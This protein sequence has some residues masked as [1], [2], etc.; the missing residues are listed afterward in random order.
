MTHI[1]ADD[2][3]NVKENAANDG[4]VVESYERLINVARSL[5]REKD[6][7]RL[8]EMILDEARAICRADAGTLYTLGEDKQFLTFAV[9][10]N[11]TLKIR[12]RGEQAADEYPRIPLYHGSKPNHAQVSS[13]AALTGETVNIGD[14]YQAEKF[15]FEGP[16]AFDKQTGYRTR[17]MLVIPMRNHLDE[18][19][20]VLQ[21][22]NARNP[23]DEEPSPFSDRDAKIVSA[24]ASLAAVALTNT[25]LIEKLYRDLDTIRQ[26]KDNED[27]LNRKLKEAFLDIEK[28]NQEMVAALKKVRVIRLVAAAVVLFFSIAGGGIYAYHRF[29]IERQRSARPAMTGVPYGGGEES[30]VVTPQPLS[31]SVSLAGKLEPLKQVS[32]VCPFTGKVAEKFFEYG[33]EVD[34][35]QLLLK[36]D[37]EELA[38]RIRDATA[39]YIRADQKLQE[40]KNWRQGTEAAQARRALSRSKQAMDTAARNR[41][42]A[43]VLFDKGIISRSELESAEEALRNAQLEVNSAEDSLSA[44]LEKGSPDNVRVAEFE[45]E[46]A[47]MELNKLKEQMETAEVVSPVNGVILLPPVTGT[48]TKRVERGVSVNQG[49]M[50]VSVGDLEGYS[51]K[52]RVDEIDIG[53]IKIGQPVSV[54]G[55]AFP[56]LTLTGKVSHTSSQAGIA[57]GFSQVP[58]FDVTVTIAALPSAVADVLRLGMSCNLQVKVYNNPEA[59]MVPIHLIHTDGPG[60]WVYVLQKTTGGVERVPVKTGMTTIDA[61]EILDGLKAGDTVVMSA[62]DSGDGGDSAGNENALTDGIR[63]R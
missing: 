54:T 50:L 37:T 38:A 20:G 55:D 51:V 7:N 62:G 25:R 58:M 3:M 40:I 27:E 36:M 16:K 42:D 33:Q 17:S 34:K 57:D 56:D 19:L 21:L 10:Q 14:V 4:R 29:T 59:L 43:K 49:E 9:M 45:Y 13:F 22:L 8:L 2:E 63:R 23:G 30:Y 60:P 52:C 61:V 35:G 11:D 46:N 44:V 41:D 18:T 1:Q 53:K 6:A 28:S 31:S 47:N 12:T 26:L 48:E 39:K 24:L 32:V 5:S 15:D